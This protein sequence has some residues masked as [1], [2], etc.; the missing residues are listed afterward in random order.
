VCH[1][2]WLWVAKAKDASIF[3]PGPYGDVRD[4]LFDEGRIKFKHFPF[5]QREVNS[6]DIRHTLK[7]KTGM[8]LAGKKKLYLFPL[9]SRNSDLM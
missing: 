3:P 4:D 8:T 1:D 6:L 5:S 9:L 7:E 2:T